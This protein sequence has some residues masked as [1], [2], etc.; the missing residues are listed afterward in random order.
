MTV[1]PPSRWE[2][3][4][5]AEWAAT[6]TRL[7]FT[8]THLDVIGYTPEDVQ[9]DLLKVTVEACRSWADRGHEDQPPENWIGCAV[10]RRRRQIRDLVW[11]H[12]KNAS[13]GFIPVGDIGERGDTAAPEEDDSVEVDERQQAMEALIH[14][15]RC[16]L[17]PAAFAVLYL[18][19][20]RE[21]TPVEIAEMSGVQRPEDAK[22]Y[23]Q[24]CRKLS[25]A[26]ASAREFLA[27]LGI[28][29]MTDILEDDDDQLARRGA[30]DPG[31][32]A[33][34]AGQRDRG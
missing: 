32:A 19:F 17:S 30:A 12:T 24:I 14:A 27:G 6:T 33:D 3:V 5:V 28:H 2:D 31:D 16:N 1:L 23:Q 26:K 15:L 8:I 34:A 4:V 21:H 7:S 10:Q 9:A 29:E 20:V 11:R 13:L 22:R 25:R 18:R